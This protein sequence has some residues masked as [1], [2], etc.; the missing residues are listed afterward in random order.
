MNRMITNTALL[1]LQQLWIILN[2]TY[3]SAIFCEDCQQH[4]CKLDR[5]RELRTLADKLF[6]QL[7][8]QFFIYV[9]LKNKG[10]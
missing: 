2:Y 3:I 7:C 4:F 6:G 10:K 1:T 9:R 8:K 5:L